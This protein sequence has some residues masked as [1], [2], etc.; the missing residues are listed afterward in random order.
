ML[1]IISWNI[2]RYTPISIWTIESIGLQSSAW[3][4]IATLTM[5]TV[6]H[7]GHGLVICS[8]AAVLLFI[9][10][11]NSRRRLCCLRPR[12]NT[13]WHLWRQWSSSIFARFSFAWVLYLKVIQ[14]NLYSGLVFEDNN[15]CIEW[16][17]NVI[18]GRERAK[19]VDIRK[20]FVDEAVETGLLRSVRVDTSEQL[21][22]VFTNSL[23][24]RLLA[25]CIAGILVRRWS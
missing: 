17:N 20:H 10:N 21:A 9:G 1:S 7:A 2:L 18:G 14:F 5:G 22:D 19:H 16:S 24:P 23:Q 13:I 3:T 12:R 25:A 4:D 15:A 8:N 6:A 11:L